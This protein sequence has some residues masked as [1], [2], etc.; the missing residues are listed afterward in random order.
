MEAGRTSAETVTAL[1]PG[2]ESTS[3]SPAST[4]S[5]PTVPVHPLAGADD[6]AAIL[7][8]ALS[9]DGA[10]IGGVPLTT[11]GEHEAAPRSAGRAGPRR[12]VMLPPFMAG[13]RKT[14][15]CHALRVVSGATLLPA[16]PR[17]LQASP[18]CS[19]LSPCRSI[20]Y[21]LSIPSWR[22]PLLPASL[23]PRFP[24][25]PTESLPSPVSTQ[26]G[27]FVSSIATRAD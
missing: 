8:F 22:G 10:G 6:Y 2:P 1:R 16:T 27:D 18:G 5:S 24:D 23:L 13:A 3:R 14:A 4:A 9:K 20:G 7:G 11:P 26:C 12:S 21:G 19:A 25:L 17:Q 15:R